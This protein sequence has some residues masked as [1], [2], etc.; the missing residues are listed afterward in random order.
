MLQKWLKKMVWNYFYFLNS[1]VVIII[2]PS[3]TV[4]DTHSFKNQTW[5][6]W[7]SIFDAFLFIWKEVL[8]DS[9]YSLFSLM[10]MGNNELLPMNCKAL[11]SV[12]SFWESSSLN[13]WLAGRLVA[14]GVMYASP[15]LS[16]ASNGKSTSRMSV[17]KAW[18][19][20]ISNG[21]WAVCQRV[22]K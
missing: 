5:E 13:F 18:L 7:E 15:S 4:N 6:C 11:R 10:S 21:R 8:F 17:I 16:S 12:R 9:F 3:K 2:I 20:C 19:F 14:V 1:I 22:L